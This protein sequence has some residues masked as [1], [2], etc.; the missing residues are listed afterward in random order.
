MQNSP[1]PDYRT[2]A[3]LFYRIERRPCVGKAKSRYSSNLRTARKASVGIWTVPSAR[4][5]FLPFENAPRFKS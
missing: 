1:R 3:V 2:G 4:I 5:F